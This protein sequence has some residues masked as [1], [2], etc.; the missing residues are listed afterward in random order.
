MATG[1]VSHLALVCGTAAA[2]N[3]TDAVM[4]GK[5]VAPRLVA[6]GLAFVSLT[7]AGGLMGRYD[8]AIALAWVFLLAS[9]VSRGPAFIRNTTKVTTQNK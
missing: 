2:I 1:D 8:F 4:T 7:V 3:A 5:E 9:L 6:S